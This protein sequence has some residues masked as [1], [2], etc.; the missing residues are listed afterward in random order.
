MSYVKRENIP[1][2]AGEQAVE[3][4]TGDLVAISCTNTRSGSNLCLHA[5]A[6]AVHPDGK[7]VLDSAGSPIDS[8]HP[9]TATADSIAAHG[10]EALVRDCMMLVLGE[11]T[12]V[13]QPSPAVRAAA[14]I[15]AALEA[16]RH[17]GAV[18]PGAVL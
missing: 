5:R 18:D 4:D 3:L 10:V 15:R 2:A 1:C 9:H 16:A 11:E 6:R 12:T 14:D 13:L 8:E 17:E 7:P